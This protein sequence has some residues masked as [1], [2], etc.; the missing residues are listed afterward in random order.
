MSLLLLR[1]ILELDVSAV[2]HRLERT[3]F[4]F[5]KNRFADTFTA[6]VLPT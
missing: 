5:M 6:I 4:I 2:Y 1:C 3:G